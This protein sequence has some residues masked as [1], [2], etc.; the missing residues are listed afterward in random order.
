LATSCQ[1][2]RLRRDKQRSRGIVA[3]CI[4]TNNVERPAQ[5]KVPGRWT[6]GSFAPL[7]ADR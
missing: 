1:L 3:G 4:R 7:L 6:G 2:F 5:D